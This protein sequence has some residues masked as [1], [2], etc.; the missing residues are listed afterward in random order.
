MRSTIFE[1]VVLISVVM[2]V[3]MVS[4]QAKAGDGEL[5][6]ER[7]EMEQPVHRRFQRNLRF[8]HDRGVLVRVAAGA[9]YSSR[10][11]GVIVEGIGVTPQIAVGWLPVEATAIHLSG[12]GSIGQSVTT[13]GAGPG[14]T[15]Y[16]E[17]KENLW[18]S[19]QI[20]PVTAD[21]GGSWFEQWALGG[22]LEAGLFGWTGAR[23]SMGGSLFGGVEGIDLD[24]DQ[25]EISGW[26]LGIRVGMVYN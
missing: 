26:R 5:D 16:F 18:V 7:V 19:A 20:G 6:G 24:G 4:T 8:N 25:K 3:A 21:A 23:F 22:E 1:M 14:V 15:H 12:W 2:S 13:V 17:Q 11:V 9:G 10:E